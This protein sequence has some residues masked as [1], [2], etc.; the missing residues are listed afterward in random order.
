MMQKISRSI[1]CLFLVALGVILV[2]EG[3]RLMMMHTEMGLRPEKIGPG[4]YMAI[5][6]VMLAV[7]A[8]AELIK[9]VPVATDSGKHAGI[10]TLKTF[11]LLVFC[12]TLMPFS[13]FTLSVGLF[14]AIYMLLVARQRLIGAFVFTAAVMTAY[15]L[16]FL[17]LAK[18]VLPRGIVGF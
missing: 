10:N 14:L 16:I 17:K 11:F 1:D 5:I 9:R 3:L 4:T 18:I 13:G 12:V 2:V 15:Y 6:G 7:F 8:T